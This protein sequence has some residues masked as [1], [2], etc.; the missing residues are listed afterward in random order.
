MKK[1]IIDQFLSG[2][3]YG[4][5]I[6]NSVLRFHKFLTGKGIKSRIIALTIDDAVREYGTPLN[7]YNEAP[8]SVRIYH[9]AISSPLNDY[10]LSGKRDRDIIVYHNITPSRYFRGYSDELVSLTEKGRDELSLFSDKFVLTVADSAFNASE[11][12]ELGFGNIRIFPI[13]VAREDYTGEYSKSYL[14]IFDDGRKN[15]LFV[16]RITPNK[17]IEDLIKFISV[18]KKIVSEDVRMIIAGNQNSVP[19]YFSSLLKLKYSLGLGISDVFFTGH[20]PF[21]ELLSVYR[22]ADL[23]LSMS[24]HEGF[25]LP[26][27]ESAFFELPVIAY[28]AGAVKETLGGSG[29][30]FKDKDMEKLAILVEKVLSDSDLTGK[31]KNKSSARAASF[32]KEADPEQLLKMIREAVDA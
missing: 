28:D 22:S 23:F 11:L 20:I 31:L 30:L 2:F 6:G 18:F 14:N 9:Y 1:M 26:L 16:G 24:E 12:S 21:E 25:C 3:H 5:A 15:I 13:M 17:K 7:E 8:G 4:D 10:F 32:G 19:H 27:I 29:I